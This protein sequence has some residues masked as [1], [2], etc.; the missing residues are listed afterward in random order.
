MRVYKG[1]NVPKGYRW[2]SRMVDHQG[3]D[4]LIWPFSCCTPGY[5]AFNFEDRRHLA[6]RWMCEQV[7]GP[8][9]GPAFHAAHSC[10]NRR[11]VNPTHL[12]WK[13]QRDNQLDRRTHGTNN[14]TRTKISQMQADQIRALRGIETPV[15]TASKY[16][17][18]ESNV[19]Q[20]Q[21][22]KT[23]ANTGKMHIWTPAEDAQLRAQLQLKLPIKEV[24]SA[25]GMSYGAV[26][27][28]MYRLRL[29]AQNGHH[30]T[31]NFKGPLQHF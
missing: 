23:W 3:D 5:G 28:R 16:G 9:P 8:A 10:G 24:A 2:I 13:T 4:C 14:K 30:G 19:R 29:S 6:H 18:T 12:S 27:A 15:E 26:T 22:G 20:I 21:E 7:H 17:V 25:L 1:S 31:R 11:C